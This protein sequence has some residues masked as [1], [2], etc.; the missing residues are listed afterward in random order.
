[1]IPLNPWTVPNVL[2]FIRLGCAFWF[3]IAAIF[4]RD[5]IAHD[6]QLGF[7]L[8]VLGAVTDWLDGYISRRWPTQRSKLGEWMDPPADKLL[9]FGYMGYL[10]ALGIATGWF[11][12]VCFVIIIAREVLMWAWRSVV[13]ADLIPVRQ[14]GKW[15]T[16]AQMLALGTYGLAFTHPMLLPLGMTLLALASAITLWSLWD[17]MRDAQQKQQESDF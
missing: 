16:A 7:Y 4:Q 6:A 12:I 17:Y 9:V 13:G 15:K 8:F 5:T 2:T 1:M 3:I 14:L 11:E 10:Y